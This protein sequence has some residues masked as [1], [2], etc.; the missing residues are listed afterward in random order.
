MY[1]ERLGRS[2]D[3]GVEGG[4]WHVNRIPTR[5]KK[6]VDCEISLNAF[7]RERV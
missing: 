1:V 5:T 2:P 3:N 7:E 4:R 6:T